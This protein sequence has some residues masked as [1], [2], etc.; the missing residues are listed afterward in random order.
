MLKRSQG[1]P[2]TVC[3]MI[4]GEFHTQTQGWLS[5]AAINVHLRLFR[6]G[7]AYF[8]PEG[9]TPEYTRTSF[10]GVPRRVH[11]HLRSLQSF[12]VVQYGQT[13]WS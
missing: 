11:Y 6:E 10:D 7:V 13:R 9:H 8:S 3:R 5:T 2:L 4:V 12:C 1:V